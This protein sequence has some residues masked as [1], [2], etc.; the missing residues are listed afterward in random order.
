MKNDHV[1]KAFA[2]LVEGTNVHESDGNGGG[3]QNGG[4]PAP[5]PFCPR[6]FIQRFQHEPATER[7]R[8]N[9][10]F[11][12]LLDCEL[13]IVNDETLQVFGEEFSCCNGCSN[14]PWEN[15]EPRVPVARVTGPH[16]KA[17]IAVQRWREFPACQRKGPQVFYGFGRGFVEAMNQ[18]DNLLALF[19]GEANEC[20]FIGQIAAA[21]ILTQGDSKE[22]IHGPRRPSNR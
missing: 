18:K 3:H 17:D 8:N 13:S 15:E 12:E 19:A 10:N 5:F 21:A 16:D 4:N 22:V 9:D 1:G 14:F 11:R 20:E 7:V 6:E 2:S